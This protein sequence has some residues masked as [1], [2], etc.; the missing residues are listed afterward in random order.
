[1]NIKLEIGNTERVLTKR[2]D[3]ILRV[4]YGWEEDESEP[5]AVPS[6]LEIVKGNQD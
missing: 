2:G 1:M 6:F 3:K 4:F 5:L